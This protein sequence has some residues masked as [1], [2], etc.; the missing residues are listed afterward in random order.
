M[1]NQE[2]MQ[3]TGIAGEPAV[4]MRI[5]SILIPCYMEREFIRGCL[6]SVRA[7]DVPDGWSAEVI[8]VDGMSTDGT[9]AIVM[10]CA[11]GDSRIRLVDNIR[12]IQSAA[13]NIGIAESRGEY[14]MRLD[15]HSTYPTDYLRLCL[16][17]AL[18]TGADNT[19]GI[20]V[21]M[22][23]GE[24]Y[25]AKLVQALTT[26][27]FGV[28]DSGFRTGAAGGEVDTVPYGFFKRSVFDRVGLFDE[29]LIRAQDYE[30]NARIRLAGGKIWMNPAIQL[31]YYQQPDLPT[32]IRKQIVKEA[33]YNAYMWYVA[34]YSFRIRHAVTGVF[35]AGMILGLLLASATRPI[36][37]LFGATMA[38][39]AAL[40]LASAFQQALRYRE[41]RHVFVLP[42]SFF[43]YHFLHGTGVLFGLCRLATGTAPVQGH[44]G[45]TL[46][47]RPLRRQP[48][49]DPT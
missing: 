23:R 8:V 37:W 33:P 4:T 5:V 36:A 18:R 42:V 1:E 10:E 32:F 22:P 35:A 43:L 21:T 6:D 38:L 49:V 27:K 40:A 48:P 44:P 16:E 11:A 31:R 29:R 28:G 14:V 15:A 47:E 19:G 24:G 2:F 46:P 20:A 34:P 17:T 26:H 41:V 7:F 30:M 3:E 45:Q 39:Y 9:R 12:R 13:L 25:G